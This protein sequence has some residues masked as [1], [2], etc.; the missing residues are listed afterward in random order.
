MSDDQA[1]ATGSG[2]AG[3]DDPM[4]WIDAEMS[5][6]K[7]EL[8]IASRQYGQLQGPAQRL[9]EYFISKTT[10][11]VMMQCTYCEHQWVRD[12]AQEHD[13]DCPVGLVFDALT[14]ASATDAGEGT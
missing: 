6:L 3:G 9:A 8:R 1:G 2:R 11:L 12:G 4:S 14:A 10:T 7:A 13:G 5:R